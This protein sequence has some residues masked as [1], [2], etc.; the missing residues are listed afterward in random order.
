MGLFDTQQDYRRKVMQRNMQ[1]LPQGETPE[2]QIARG[3]GQMAMGIWGQPKQE[4]AEMQ[5]IAAMQTMA[6]GLNPNDP[7]SFDVAAKG[8]FTVDPEAAMQVLAQKKALFGDKSEEKLYYR[9]KNIDGDLI[10]TDAVRSVG[11]PPKEEGFIFTTSPQQKGKSSTT[12]INTTRD[13]FEVADAKQYERI[14]ESSELATESLFNGERALQLLNKGTFDTGT[15]AEF[16][17]SA[18]K[19]L[20]GLGV[21]PDKLTGISNITDKA[22]YQKRTLQ[23]GLSEL[24]KQKGTQS[25]ND[26]KVIFKSVAGLGDTS[27]AAKMVLR[28]SIANDYRKK[29][30]DTFFNNKQVIAQ[31][32]GEP[33][34][35]FN[36]AKKEWEEHM[37]SSP[38][39]KTNPKGALVFKEEYIRSYLAANKGLSREDAI[40][41][42]SSK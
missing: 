37:K 18:A 26:M 36:K 12:N 3:L 34:G 24:T 17:L 8:M 16:R 1:M 42:W 35:W 30:K 33:R 19:A 25:E 2:M 9:N 14:S 27:A 5:K 41:S 40:N 29:E 4:G 11:P 31:E 32:R 7:N 21:S 38:M 23:V 15:F 20:E 10:T 39:V 13:P 6:A 22:E 28:A